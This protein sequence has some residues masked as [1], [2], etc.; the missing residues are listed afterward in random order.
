M[1]HVWFPTLQ[2]AYSI[3]VY[4]PVVRTVMYNCTHDSRIPPRVSFEEK[5]AA[6]KDPWRHM[7]KHFISGL[8]ITYQCLQHVCACVFFLG[9]AQVVEERQFAL[10]FE[11]GNYFHSTPFRWPSFSIPLPP[12][13]RRSQVPFPMERGAR[14]TP[15]LRGPVLPSIR[16]SFPQRHRCRRPSTRLRQ[17]ARTAAYCL[18]S[19]NHGRT[20]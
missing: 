14:G 10:G 7:E 6:C 16:P 15:C 17:L 13:F 2:V 3:S 1:C 20:C 12:A 8:K 4:P 19:S 18:T 9:S 11:R 5:G